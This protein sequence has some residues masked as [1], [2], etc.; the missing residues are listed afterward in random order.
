MLQ[1]DYEQM[2]DAQMLD[3]PL[4]FDAL[5]E[6]VRALQDV[7]NAAAQAWTVPGD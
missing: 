7:V 2:L 1:A 5:V 4:S 3:D 6:R